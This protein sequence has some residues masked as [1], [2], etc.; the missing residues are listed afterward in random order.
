MPHNNVR[1]PGNFQVLKCHFSSE[2]FD[3]K[4]SAQLWLVERKKKNP[5]W[6]LVGGSET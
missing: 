5:S 1:R 3:L 2:I 6:S 4:T